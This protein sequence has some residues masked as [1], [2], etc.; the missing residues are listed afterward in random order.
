MQNAIKYSGYNSHLAIHSLIWIYIEQKDFNDAIKV[1]ELALKEHP[2]SRI[3]KWGLARSYEN[4][5]PAKSVE[6]YREILHSY[7]KNLNQT[8][9]MK[10]H[11]SI[12]LHS[13]LSKSI[14]LLK[15]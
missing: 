14:K 5:D 7:P 4:I 15:R 8:R 1:A 13:N 3:F 10:L 2:Q 9:L 11:L 12:L 6:L